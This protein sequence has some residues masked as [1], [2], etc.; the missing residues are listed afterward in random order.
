MSEPAV[1]IDERLYGYYL[2]E[3]RAT[4]TKPSLSDFV[5]WAQEAD[6]DL[7]PEEQESLDAD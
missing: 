2:Q 6:Y 1:D 5:L 3:C 7:A 4:N